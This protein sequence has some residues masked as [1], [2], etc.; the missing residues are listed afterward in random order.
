M[1]L[2]G[3]KSTGHE[4]LAYLTSAGHRASAVKRRGLRSRGYLRV[5]LDPDAIVEVP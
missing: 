3:A 1:F 2:T 5:G 4:W